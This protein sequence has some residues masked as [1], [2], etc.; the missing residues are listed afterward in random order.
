MLQ[1]CIKNL[2]HMRFVTVKVLYL[3]I[4]KVLVDDSVHVLYRR[5]NLLESSS[6]LLSKKLIID[7]NAIDTESN[8][9]Y[10]VLQKNHID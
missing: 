9:L 10:I 6:N 5:V 4:K 2:K 7:D 8:L 3:I 1:V